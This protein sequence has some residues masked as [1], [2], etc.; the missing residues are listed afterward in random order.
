LITGTADV[1]GGAE[2]PPIEVGDGPICRIS[3]HVNSN[4]AYVGSQVPVPFVFRFS[5]DNT[6]RLAD[7]SAVTRSEIKYLDGSILITAP[8]AVHL[9]DINLN[10]VAY[11]IGDAVYFS[12]FFISPRLFPLNEQQLLN[13]DVNRD[14]V[15]PS[16]A[17]LVLLINIVAGAVAPP[18]PKILPNP[19]TATATL[20]RENSGLYLALESPVEMG[21]ALFRLSGPDIERVEAQNLTT[22][23]YQADNWQGR[24]SCLLISYDQETIPSGETSVIRLSD[25]PDLD[26]TLDLVDAAD[27]E[28]RPLQINIKETAAV[29]GVFALHQNVP[30]P[31]N[32]STEIRFDLASPEHVTLTVYN[33]LGQEVIRL[34]DG[35]YPAG[36]H[37]AVW[38]GVDGNG[39]PAAS[40]MYLYR[41]VAGK[42]SAS[43]KMVLM[44]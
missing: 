35:D 34:I 28:G 7:G 9:G 27:A 11:E 17:D 30:N 38:D 40:G 8:G 1:A 20:R 22:M 41:L 44:K 5:D 37:T 26:I 13:S 18:T 42:D 23:D 12:N 4:L 14:G 21:G 24:F 10:G 2:T 16:V 43:R 39:R 3:V 33:I 31:F 6:M 19:Q 32:P 36:C 29:P 25:D 15:A